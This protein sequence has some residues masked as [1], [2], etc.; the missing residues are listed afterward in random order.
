MLMG[1]QCTVCAHED[2]AIINAALID[3][4]PLESLSKKYGVTVAA[5]HRHKKHIP[6]ALVKAQ[7]AKEVA[8]A[9]SLMVRV[10]SLNAKAEEVYLRALKAD[11]LTAAIGAVR[12]LRGILELYAKITGELQSQTV[13]NIVVAPEWVSLRDV[14]LVALEPHPAARKAVISAMRRLE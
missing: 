3:K 12:E 2:A 9:D 7:D 4:I 6:H 5:L 1:K 11:N 13:N 14:I 8:A 10:S